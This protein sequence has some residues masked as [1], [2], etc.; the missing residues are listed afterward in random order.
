MSFELRY[1]PEAQ[2]D[3][4]KV[5][6]DVAF[7]SGDF[8]VADRYVEEFADIVASKKDYPRSGRPLQYRGLFTGFYSVDYKAYKAFYRVTDD[9]IEV[10]RIIPQKMDYL[11]ILFGESE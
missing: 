4:D 3:M 2:Q 1:S 5:W 11:K 7:A 10:I 6:D 9:W 8:D